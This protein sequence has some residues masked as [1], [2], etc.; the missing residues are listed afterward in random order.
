MVAR[1]YWEGQVRAMG[2]EP[3]SLLKE[4][5]SYNPF[6]MEKGFGPFGAPVLVW[7]GYA[8][9]SQQDRPTAQEAGGVQPLA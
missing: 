2:I 3:A 5:W 8:G 6:W 1:Q 9:Q 7:P 4:M